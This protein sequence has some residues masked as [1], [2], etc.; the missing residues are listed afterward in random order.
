MKVYLV[1][2]ND[3]WKN[4]HKVPRADHEASTTSGVFG[5]SNF[6]VNLSVLKKVSFMTIVV[7][8]YYFLLL[9]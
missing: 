8:V 4:R 1:S 6:Y 7:G 5:Y 9:L 2:R 3:E